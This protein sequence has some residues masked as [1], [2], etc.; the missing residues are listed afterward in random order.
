MERRN[1]GKSFSIIV[2]SEGARAK[3]IMPDDISEDD[4]TSYFSGS[5]IFLAKELERLTSLENRITVLGYLQRGG[6]PSAYDR[7]LATRFGASAVSIIDKGE[8]NRMVC[9]DHEQ[10]KSVPLKDVANK[11]RTVPVNG[12]M[13][14]IAKYMDVCLGD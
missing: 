13:V 11:V 2:M 7:I 10:I 8:F 5:S 12:E 9:V 4:K 1:A 3:D 6:E 14:Q